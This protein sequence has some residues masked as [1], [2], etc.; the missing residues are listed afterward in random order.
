MTNSTLGDLPN[1]TALVMCEGVF[2][3]ERELN[4][5][6]NEEDG[7]QAI[8]ALNHR[9]GKCEGMIVGLGHLYEWEPGLEF[10]RDLEFGHYAWKR[11]GTWE[12]GRLEQGDNK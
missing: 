3:R 1:N 11:E 8:C 7:P 2:N 4:Y 5:V 9:D 6:A 12:I 10:L